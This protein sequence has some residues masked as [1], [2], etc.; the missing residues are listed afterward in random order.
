MHLF[1]ISARD[2]ECQDSLKQSVQVLGK[3]I[4]KSLFLPPKEQKKG[5]AQVCFLKSDS[6][7]F[8]YVCV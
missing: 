6:K 7:I 5:K 4:A 8:D 2:K 1:F 3:P